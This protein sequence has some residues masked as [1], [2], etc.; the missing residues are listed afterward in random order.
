MQK[1]CSCSN[2]LRIYIE[3][4]IQRKKCYIMRVPHSH[5]PLHHF[6]SLGNEVLQKM[7][8]AKY[9]G[10]QID[11]NINWNKHNSTVADRGQSKLPFLNRNLKGCPKKMRDAAY[12]SHLGSH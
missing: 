4:E 8:D 11:N 5:K 7:S 6:Y 9:L 12:I 2:E 3:H 10:I 1:K